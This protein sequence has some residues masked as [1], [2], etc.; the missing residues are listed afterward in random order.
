MSSTYTDLR[1]EYLNEWRIWY[2]MCKRCREDMTYYVE[3]EVCDEWQ[4]EQGFVN[5]LDDMG[6]RPTPTSVLDRVNKFGDY[7]PGNVVWTTKKESSNNGRAHNDKS[8]L[9]Y[10]R[11]EAESNG[12]NRHTF[13]SRVRDHGWNP[14]D[15]ATIPVSKTKYKK[16]LT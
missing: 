15:A 13:Y 4:G 5:W 16:R 1:A 12:I 2:R 6:P 14:I 3:V 9:P 10:W 8:K 7:E 11:K